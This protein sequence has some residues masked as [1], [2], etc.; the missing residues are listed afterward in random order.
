MAQNGAYAAAFH[1]S[2]V[3]PD[4]GQASAKKTLVFCPDREHGY[5]V[6]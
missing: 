4:F 1:P 5:F 6:I 2:I 3:A